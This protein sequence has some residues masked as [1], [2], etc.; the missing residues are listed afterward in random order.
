MLDCGFRR[1]LLCASQHHYY[2]SSIYIRLK[3]LPVMIVMWFVLGSF[4][5]A[6]IPFVSPI[7]YLLFI[8]GVAA[9]LF[10]LFGESKY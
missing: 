9:L 6:V 5:V 10:K 7:I 1:E 3:S 4:W 8:F 2:V